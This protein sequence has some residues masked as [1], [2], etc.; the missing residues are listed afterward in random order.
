MSKIKVSKRQWMHWF[1]KYRVILNAVFYKLD[2]LIFVKEV[3]NVINGIK[4]RKSSR[5]E[6]FNNDFLHICLMI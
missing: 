5:K 3:V 6:C 1:F 2:V 4:C